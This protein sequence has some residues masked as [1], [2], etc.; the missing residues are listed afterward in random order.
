MLQI[1]LLSKRQVNISEL[2]L[3]R[4]FFWLSKKCVETNVYTLPAE[5]EVES[6]I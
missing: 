4:Q 5:I 2:N 1:I 6:L 3:E